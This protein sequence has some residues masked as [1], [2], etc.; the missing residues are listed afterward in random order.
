MQRAKHP[1]WSV[2][3]KSLITIH[4]LITYG[5]EK[6]IQNIA[7]SKVNYRTFEA[8]T[9]FVDSTTSQAYNMST[10]LRRYSHYLYTK[11]ITY[12]AIGADLCKIKPFTNPKHIDKVENT[13]LK[14]KKS[15]LYTLI[16]PLINHNFESLIAFDASAEDLNNGIITSAFSMLY[17][18]FV[19]LY[20]LYQACIVILLN[21]Y[22][23]STQVKFVRNLLNIYKK[24]LTKMDKCKD[25]MRVVDSVGIDKS[26]MPK[27]SRVPALPLKSMEDHLERVTNESKNRSSL[28]QSALVVE[29]PKLQNNYCTLAR[30]NSGRQTSFSKNR[31]SIS[32]SSI[33][34]LNACSKQPEPITIQMKGNKSAPG[35]VQQLSELHE[36][37]GEFKYTQ[38]NNSSNNNNDSNNN[39]NNIN[40]PNNNNSSSTNDTSTESSTSSSSSS[41]TDKRK[42]DSYYY[43][44]ELDPIQRGKMTTENKYRKDDKDMKSHESKITSD[45]SFLSSYF[46]SSSN[47][48]QTTNDVYQS[49]E[50]EVDGNETKNTAEV[51]LMIVDDFKDVNNSKNEVSEKV[52]KSAEAKS[53]NETSGQPTSS[54]ISKFRSAPTPD[55][56]VQVEL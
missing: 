54:S 36:T 23:E 49:L 1:D 44:C 27:V 14:L 32:P 45:F 5:N 30:R 56:W 8:H 35:E 28:Y 17:K 9:E 24:F 55:D 25:F 10:F 34:K 53:E 21:T 13:P 41:T 50:P 51:D 26:D 22:F 16:V 39:N 31:E 48:P 33:S 19:K 20:I 38:L 18:D 52:K 47:K 3:F 42:R 37:S 7:T 40:N 43:Y 29:L 15:S 2:T 6:F 11:V 4:H 46:E 12:R